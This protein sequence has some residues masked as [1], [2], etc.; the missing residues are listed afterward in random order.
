LK[1]SKNS[2]KSQNSNFKIL[3]YHF[4]HLCLLCIVKKFDSIGTKL[5]EEIHFEVCPY[6]HN[7]SMDATPPSSAMR[8]LQAALGLVFPYQA[9]RL[10][11]RTSLKWPIL[12]RVDVKSQLNQSSV[13]HASNQPRVSQW[14]HYLEKRLTLKLL[15][16][17]Q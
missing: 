7:A 11:W 16:L 1:I 14:A 13:L 3:V 5:T 12:C 15:W 10:A 2:Q 9:K 17:T 6:R 4:L 8:P